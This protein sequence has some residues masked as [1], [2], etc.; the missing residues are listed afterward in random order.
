VGS[1]THQ[2]NY[3]N[4]NCL[5]RGEKGEVHEGREKDEMEKRGGRGRER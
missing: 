2:R 3:L 1:H 5:C 4:L